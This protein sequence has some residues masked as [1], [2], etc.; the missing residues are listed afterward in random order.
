MKLRPSLVIPP[1][2]VRQLPDG[3]YLAFSLRFPDLWAVERGADAAAFVFRLLVQKRLYGQAWRWQNSG[4]HPC[5]T[6][7]KEGTMPAL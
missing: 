2:V 1:P 7:G 6:D 3:R 5:D 4:D